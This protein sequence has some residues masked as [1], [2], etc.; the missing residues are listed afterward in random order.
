MIFFLLITLFLSQLPFFGVDGQHLFCQST[1]ECDD[2]NN[3]TNPDGV[4]RCDA[5]SSCDHVDLIKSGQNYG[6]SGHGSYSIYQSSIIKT[7]S[8]LHVID[9][10]MSIVC[11]ALIPLNNSI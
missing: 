8:T 10:I 9:I 2:R 4:I 6:I 7:I 1:H 3:L 11:I 5:F